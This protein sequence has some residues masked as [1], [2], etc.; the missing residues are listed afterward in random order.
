M[1][2]QHTPA[3]VGAR[4]RSGALLIAVTAFAVYTLIG[5]HTPSDDTLGNLHLPLAMLR[6]GEPLLRLDE[7]PWARQS[8]GAL[9][10]FV[11]ETRFPGKLASTFGIGAPLTALPAFAIDQWLNGPATPARAI[12]LGKVVAAA[13][14]AATAALIFLIAARTLSRARALLVAAVFAFATCAWGVGSQALWQQ[15]PNILYLTLG[16]YCLCRSY[17][18]PV[19]ALACGASLAMAGLVRPTS[20][21]AFVVVGLCSLPRG[22]AFVVRYALGALPIGLIQAAYNQWLFGAP[23]RFGQDLA[24]VALAVEKT[25]TAHIWRFAYLESV[26]GMLFSPSRGLLVYSPV[27]A[28][29]FVGLYLLRRRPEYRWML[30]LVAAAAG[31]ALVQATW[32]DWW[33]GWSFGYRAL[34]D[35]TPFLALLLVPALGAIPVRSVAFAVFMA[36]A[37]WSVAVQVL[38]V[39]TYS[40]ADSWEQKGCDIDRA[41]C[42]SRLWSVRDSQL[43]FLAGRLVGRLRRAASVS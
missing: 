19:F 9:Q 29:A 35:V 12:A 38:G 17:Q 2:S 1:A 23:W 36:A 26:P 37:T 21:L 32:Y 20:W 43:V 40:Y 4:T 18:R 41:E 25:G 15:S 6:H 28:F 10:Y 39:S 13:C 33:G 30:P 11:L 5:T 7:F 27:F 8:S 14:M 16:A 24:G 31:I 34:L 42:R 22:R 3:P